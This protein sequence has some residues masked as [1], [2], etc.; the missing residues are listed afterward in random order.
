[1][2]NFDVDEAVE[3]AG[4]THANSANSANPDPGTAPIRTI[5][6]ISTTPLTNLAER[7][8]EL[9]E[10]VNRVASYNG[11]TPEQRQE[12]IEIGLGDLD[13]ALECFRILAAKLPKPDQRRGQERWPE[14]PYEG[15]T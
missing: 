3:K 15:V 9:T 1:M 5:S 12:A 13:A 2:F 7:R 10:L 14:L 8:A 6:M 11:F 4:A